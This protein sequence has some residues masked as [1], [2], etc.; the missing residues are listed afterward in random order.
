MR[1]CRNPG[2][3]G[4]LAL[5]FFLFFD[6]R[7]TMSETTVRLNRRQML[8]TTGKASAVLALPTLLPAASLGRDGVVAPSERI[9]LGGIGLGGRGT[10]VLR[11]FMNNPDVQFVAIC[12]IRRQRREAVKNLADNHYGNEDCATYRDM[13]EI[14]ARPDIDSV[15]IAT[16]DRWHAM[17]S[18][19]AAKAGKDV[20]CEK[21]CSMT[22]SESQALADTFRRYGVIYQAGTQRRSIG[23]FQFAA[24]LAHSGRL[25]KLH[26]VHANTL[27]PPTRHDWLP[28]QPEPPKEEVDWDAWLGPCPWRPYNARY[29]AGGWRGFFDF[30]GGG[31]LEW[32]SH[33]VDLCQWAGQ[34]DDTAPVEYTPEGSGVIC[35]YADGLKLV[36]RDSGWMGLGTCSVRYE[37][38]EGWIETGDSGRFAIYPETLRTERTVFTMAGTDPST[39]VRNFLD[40]VK[41]RKPANS[42]SD[43]AAQSHIACHAAYIAWQLGRTLKYDPTIDAFEDE[44]ANRM[45]SRAMREPYRV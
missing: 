16:G 5:L 26:T 20:F 12:D 1:A 17:A 29:V 30:H 33:T 13:D 23:N 7:C 37:G 42:N 44:E 3:G 15:L 4:G 36:M 14:L 22:I 11:S 45:R 41:T 8:A 31:I 27:N 9:V 19:I 40:C 38:D 10:G 39:H 21:P 34:K 18:I 2:T 43:V 6:R 32:G 28:A 35:H 24:D 25:G